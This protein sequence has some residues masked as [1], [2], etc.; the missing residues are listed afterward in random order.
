MTRIGQDLLRVW[1]VFRM[2]LVL[3]EVPTLLG[4]STDDDAENYEGYLSTGTKVA[5]DDS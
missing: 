4:R 3:M 2:K 1:I 5:T